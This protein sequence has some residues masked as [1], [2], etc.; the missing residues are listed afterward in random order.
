MLLSEL[1]FKY[2][3]LVYDAEAWALLNTNVAALRVF[4]RKAPCNIFS[5]VC[6]GNNFRIR[7]N[8]ELLNKVEIVQP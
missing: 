6:I 7:D 1:G 2:V 5:P 4:R 3:L 8:N